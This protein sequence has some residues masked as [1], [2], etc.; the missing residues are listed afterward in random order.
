MKRL[1]AILFSLL[2]VWMQAVAAT[3]AP[4][5]GVKRAVC[6]CCD[7]GRTDCCVTPTSVPAAPTPAAPIRTGVQ[8]ELGLFAPAS[9]AWTLPAVEVQVFSPAAFSPLTTADVPLF[10]RHCALLI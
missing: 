8:N 2:L 6:T 10:T 3:Q 5:S 4:I 1:F 9:V 7:C